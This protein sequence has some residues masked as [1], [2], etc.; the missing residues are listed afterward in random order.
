MVTARTS[1]ADHCQ[2]VAHWHSF[3][4]HFALV[5]SFS[6]V[7]RSEG[8]GKA[9]VVPLPVRLLYLLA[10]IAGIYHL[11]PIAWLP[12]VVPALT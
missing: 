6:D 12:C 3:L 9:N 2:C 10:V 8:M 11:I 1:E 7:L 4:T 5:D